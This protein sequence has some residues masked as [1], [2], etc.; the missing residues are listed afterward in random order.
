MIGAQQHFIAQTFG[1]TTW[2]RYRRLRKSLTPETILKVFS[3]VN[4][5]FFGTTKSN[6]GHTSNLNRNN[7]N[8]H[9]NS[10]RDVLD[11]SKHTKS[12]RKHAQDLS[13]INHTNSSLES[14]LAGRSPANR[15]DREE[16]QS[17][18]TTTPHRTSSRHSTPAGHSHH[19]QHQGEHKATHA[20][21]PKKRR[22]TFGGGGA[23]ESNGIEVARSK[24]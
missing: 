19:H 2:K 23:E 20:H 1:A 15:A 16:L 14:H 22:Q 7:S 10:Q 6:K 24:L 4:P 3:D 11:E 8:E 12:I 18:G 9:L 5:A 21:E 13:V 17:G